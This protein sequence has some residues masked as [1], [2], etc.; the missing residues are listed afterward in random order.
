MNHGHRSLHKEGR[1]PAEETLRHLG[2]EF[3]TAEGEACRGLGKEGRAG[4]TD[5]GIISIQLVVTILRVE[6]FVQGVWIETKKRVEKTPTKEKP[7]G[8]SRGRGFC[9]GTSRI[10]LEMSEEKQRTRRRASKASFQM[11]NQ[12]Q[13]TRTKKHPWI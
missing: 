1:A 10:L 8:D 4:E 2:G 12:V 6:E 13:E 11:Q 9:K 5:L 7:T 3:E